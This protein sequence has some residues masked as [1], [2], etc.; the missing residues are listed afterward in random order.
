MKYLIIWL[1]LLSTMANAKG[2]QV[3][4]RMPIATATSHN[5]ISAITA[6]GAT[7][8]SQPAFTDVSGSV[9]ASQ[10]PA[11]TGDIT[12]S[13]GAVATA[14]ATVNS[15]V[16]TFTNATVTV[17]GKGL[18]TAASNGSGGSG[19]VTSVSA[20]TVP[21]GFTSSVATSTTTPAI[22]IASN[23]Q[24]GDLYN[25]GLSASISS[26]TLV[27]ALK[28]S[29]GSTD[30]TA[31]SPC[32]GQFRSSTATTG[33]YSSTSFTA[34]TS[35]TLSATDSIGTLSATAT[36]LYIY[37]VSDST[38]EICLSL[39]QLDQRVVQSASAL[40]AGADT[41][42][43]KLWCTSA[44]TSKAIRLIGKVSAT[45]S[46]PNWGSITNLNLVKFNDAN[47]A[48]QSPGMERVERVLF[49]G[50]GT[51]TTVCSSSPCSIV[52]QS[53]AWVSSVTRSGAGAYTV[54]FAPGVFST[55]PTCLC[56]EVDLANAGFCSLNG[57]IPTTSGVTIFTRTTGVN[58]VDEAANVICM[59]AR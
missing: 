27:V 14:L 10:M 48:S 16:G 8:L 15:N 3:C 43:T 18:I 35:I 19:T 12:T 55:A 56:T 59:G 39:T 37:L 44:H 17:N 4:P 29:D 9:A 57:A 26:S 53:G 23:G 42:G 28:Q 31:A 52:S 51:G 1:L 58:G 21:N 38:S 13:A 46:N 22:T 49:A 24:A 5:W 45:W 33:S 41:D 30:C 36:A 20:P 40:T 7:T 34:A 11:L 6:G 54:N 25:I 32:I 47:V 50:N 2:L